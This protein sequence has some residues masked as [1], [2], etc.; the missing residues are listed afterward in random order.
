MGFEMDKKKKETGRERERGLNGWPP[1]PSSKIEGGVGR[2]GP[3][4]QIF[5]AKR[6]WRLATHH[7]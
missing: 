5:K 1:N 4:R 7:C 3:Q 6:E 2:S